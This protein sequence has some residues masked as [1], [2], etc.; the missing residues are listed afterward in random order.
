MAPLRLSPSPIDLL[1]GLSDILTRMTTAIVF[2]LEPFRQHTHITSHWLAGNLSVLSFDHYKGLF[3]LHLQLVARPL[4]NCQF[5]NC[6]HTHKYIHNSIKSVFI[7]AQ[8]SWLLQGLDQHTF[9]HD[10]AHHCEHGWPW[11]P[12]VFYR[13]SCYSCYY[14]EHNS[15]RHWYNSYKSSCYALT[16]PWSWAYTAFPSGYPSITAPTLTPSPQLQCAQAP[17]TTDQVC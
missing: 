14:S 15:V 6:I 5:I 12:S 8:G 9:R 3:H 13:N 17:L 11:L 10:E 2:K 16:T 1:T 7:P 4:A